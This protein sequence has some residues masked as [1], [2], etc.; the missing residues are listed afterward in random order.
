MCTP[1]AGELLQFRPSGVRISP[2]RSC[3]MGY[4][5]DVICCLSGNSRSDLAGWWSTSTQAICLLV[6]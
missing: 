6:A 5:W 4:G 1:E 2:L 3:L